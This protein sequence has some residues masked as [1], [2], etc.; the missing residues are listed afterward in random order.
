MT[1][2]AATPTQ[3]TFHY[4]KSSQFRVIH[5]DGMIGGITPR[6]LLHIAMY[7]ER[8]A[9]PQLVVQEVSPE[10]RLGAEKSR[11]GK[12]GVAR[13]VE[14]DLMFDEEVAKAFHDWL[15]E[16]LKELGKAKA[17]LAQRIHAAQ[18]VTVVT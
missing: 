17:E 6:G 11:I 10:G 4:I 12:D 16:R 15:G 5:V 14:V 8:P 18:V 7:S 9:I 2:P 13:E 1:D 3:L